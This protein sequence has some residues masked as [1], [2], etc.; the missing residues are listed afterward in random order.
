MGTKVGG[1]WNK[2]KSRY[3]RTVKKMLRESNQP[4]SARDIYFKWGT[5]APALNAIIGALPMM[6]DIEECNYTNQYGD[7][8]YK[9]KEIEK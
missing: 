6:N 8:L 1:R 2:E 4:L 7:K 9:L 3:G 5:K